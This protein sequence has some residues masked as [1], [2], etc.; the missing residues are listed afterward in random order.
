MKINFMIGLIALGF[1]TVLGVTGAEYYTTHEAVAAGLQQC[2]V[3]GT[4]VW[5]KDC[6]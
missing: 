5:Q 3:G 4:Y 2:K 1:F 6:I